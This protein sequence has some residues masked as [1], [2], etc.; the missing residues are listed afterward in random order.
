[1][2][3]GPPLT[4][5]LLSLELVRLE[6]TGGSSTVTRPFVPLF[7]DIGGQS[8]I[9]MFI[10]DAKQTIRPKVPFSVRDICKIRDTVHFFPEGLLIRDAYKVHRARVQGVG[11]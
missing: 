11:I 3:P 9:G 2:G 1:L 8:E 6:H 4:K 5:N 7:D 10:I